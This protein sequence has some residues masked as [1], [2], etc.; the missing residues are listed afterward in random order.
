MSAFTNRYQHGKPRVSR[1][2]VRPLSGCTTAIEGLQR[3]AQVTD[4]CVRTTGPNTP[5]SCT[6]RK[7]PQNFPEKYDN[8]QAKV[9]SGLTV[10][11]VI[12]RSNKEIVRRRDEA[13]YRLNSTQLE[14][15][16]SQEENYF[17]EEDDTSNDNKS[18]PDALIEKP[19]ILV[20]DVRDVHFYNACHI[21]NARS[22][23]LKSMRQDKIHHEL[24][25][26]RNK[27]SCLI[28]FYCDNELISRD[29]ASLQVIRGVNNVYLLT[30]GL[31]ELSSKC[32]DLVDG[33]LLPRELP[34]SRGIMYPKPYSYQGGGLTADRIATMRGHY[35]FM[36]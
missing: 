21:R 28:V 3:K 20:Y 18:S 6:E 10:D 8:V 19:Q 26:A 35:H 30:G 23:P 34:S 31:N 25:E 9:N 16:Y 11:K 1:A 12:F 29:A 2:I 24:L 27:N 7:A 36:A 22:Y 13:F 4:F 5:K 17:D 14:A 32:P 33:Q 15:L